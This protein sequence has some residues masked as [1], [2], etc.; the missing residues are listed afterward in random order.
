MSIYNQSKI[1]SD[2]RPEIDG[3]RALAVLAVIV[4]HL[5]V[6]LLAGGF[7]GVDVFFVI[8]G[9]L[10]TSHI[11]RDMEKGIFSFRK[12][13]LKRICRLYPALFVM[14]IIVTLVA[15]YT[16]AQPQDVFINHAY[17]T[18][19]SYENIYLKFTQRG[20][21][22]AE[23]ESIYFLHAW[24]LSLEEQFYLI[25][26]L[27]LLLLRRF[28]KRHGLAIGLVA[29]LSLALCV[30]GTYSYPG[31]TFYLLP[32][33]VWELLIGS[34]LAIRHFKS[35]RGSTIT[36]IKSSMLLAIALILI[37]APMFL[38][39]SYAH[40]PGI[41]ALLPCVGTAMIIHYSGSGTITDRFLSF[42]IINYIGRISYSLYLWHWPFIVGTRYL[43]DATW[44]AM[45]P[46]LVMSVLSYHFVEQPF[47]RMPRKKSATL[48]LLFL[49]IVVFLLVAVIAN[50]NQKL[51]RP[52]VPNIAAPES[53]VAGRDFDILEDVKK[54]Q[55]DFPIY[56][57]GSGSQLDIALL[58]S[59]HGLAYTYPLLEF[60]N[61]N[62]LRVAFLATQGSGVASIPSSGSYV[63]MV[64][65]ARSEFL[66]KN[67]PEI[68]VVAG[69]WEIEVGGAPSKEDFVTR[70]QTRL[71]KLS[72]NTSKVLILSQVPRIMTKN[73]DPYYREILLAQILRHGEMSP[74]TPAKGTKEAN[75]IV[76]A[77]VQELQLVEPSKFYFV[78]VYDLLVGGQGSVAILDEAGNFLYSDDDHLNRTGGQLLFDKSV[79]PLIKEWLVPTH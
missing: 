4:F 79:K 69:R 18:I 62:S 35:K 66:Q 59:S 46:A 72:K 7:M 2:Y 30:W 60:A 74:V 42:G 34:W 25:L 37:V 38:V 21:W 14:V 6:D 16:L 45:I 32:T 39:K 77:A 26:P 31:A 65:T 63:E 68:I 5:G 41:L 9:Y 23:S 10:I 64:Q 22:A 12:F 67:P 51:I 44:L 3:L 61:K 19:F 47:R 17:A 78:D 57:T 50:P 20:Y 8:S 28:T 54:G 36:P 40:F 55:N 13:W 75:A 49:A 53:F 33:R 71:Q 70:F 52:L 27:S 1:R 29:I 56:G 43:I 24:S 48:I 15:C 73:E 76:A 11:Y 58:G